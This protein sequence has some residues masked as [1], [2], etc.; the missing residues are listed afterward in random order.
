M[1]KLTE[2]FSDL[3]NQYT[4]DPVSSMVT[5]RQTKI[6][7]NQPVNFKYGDEVDTLSREFNLKLV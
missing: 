5:S 7:L 4:P 2:A 6:F 3:F 1:N